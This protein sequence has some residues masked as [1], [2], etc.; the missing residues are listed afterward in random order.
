[1]QRETARKLRYAEHEAQWA[2][3]GVQAACREIARPELIVGCVVR[4]CREPKR[5]EPKPDIRIPT[6]LRRAR[7]N[8]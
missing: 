7:K 2:P 8:A 1:M 4:D 3:V 6:Y 5:P